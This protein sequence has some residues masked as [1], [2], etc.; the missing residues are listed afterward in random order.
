MRRTQQQF[1][2]DILE[3]MTHAERFAEGM[4]P[5]DLVLRQ[6]VVVWSVP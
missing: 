3:M 4:T 2:N 6:S 1:I 5:E